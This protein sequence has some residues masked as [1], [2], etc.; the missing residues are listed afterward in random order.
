M[1]KLGQQGEFSRNMLEAKFMRKSQIFFTMTLLATYG[2]AAKAD[3]VSLGQKNVNNASTTPSFVWINGK[4]V[5]GLP[6]EFKLPFT[7]SEN[8][9]QTL[10]IRSFP[11]G[12]SI[13]L[14]GKIKGTTPLR[15]KDLETENEH[16][17]RVEKANY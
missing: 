15:I 14:E 1:V 10:E 17:L 16:T 11:S 4:R 3:S 6:G 12:A 2:V 13:F 7:F 5:G 8:Q 9:R